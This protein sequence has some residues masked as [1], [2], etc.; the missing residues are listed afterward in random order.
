MDTMTTTIL[1]ARMTV[2]EA[3]AIKVI[4]ARHDLK[5]SD[6]VLRGVEEL[7]PGEIEREVSF[8]AQNL[9]ETEKNDGLP[10][11]ELHAHAN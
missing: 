1:G 5:L 8:F 7:F 2:A 11:G 6:L 10:K 9:R 4:A 3:R